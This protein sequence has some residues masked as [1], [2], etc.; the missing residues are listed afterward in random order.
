M[1]FLQKHLQKA[2]KK[3]FT[4]ILSRMEPEFAKFVKVSVVK[5]FLVFSA[6]LL[7]VPMTVN[8]SVP[9]SSVSTYVDGTDFHIFV[10]IL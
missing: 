2:N 4:S 9:L 5:V 1:N 8:S 7:G 3:I 10:I 6:Q